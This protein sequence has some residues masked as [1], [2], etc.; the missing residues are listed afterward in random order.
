MKTESSHLKGFY[1]TFPSDFHV[2]NTLNQ[3]EK[4]QSK[5]GE[6]VKRSLSRGEGWT[7]KT[8]PSKS[9]MGNL[10]KFV[11][12]LAALILRIRIRINFIAPPPKE[13]ICPGT[14]RAHRP[15]KGK[16]INQHSKR[17]ICNFVSVLIKKKKEALLP[18]VPSQNNSGT[19]QRCYQLVSCLNSAVAA[20]QEVG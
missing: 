1:V 18:E 7:R 10:T 8:V 2:L 4:P 14:F 3:F 13:E 17:D 15:V 16:T 12:E 19:E 11:S 9:F 5:K 20:E 6:G